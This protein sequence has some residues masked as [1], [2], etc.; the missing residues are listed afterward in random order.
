MR[1]GPLGVEKALC[2][3]LVRGRGAGVSMAAT[4]PMMPA[5]LQNVFAWVSRLSRGSVALARA[6]GRTRR[7]ERECAARNGERKAKGDDRGGQ[8]ERGCRD[9]EAQHR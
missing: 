5:A 2:D 1:L 6:P 7:G 9:A 3:A 8:P 4:A